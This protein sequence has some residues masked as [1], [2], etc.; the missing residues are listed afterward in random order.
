M[1]PLLLTAS[2]QG[3]KRQRGTHCVCTHAAQATACQLTVGRHVLGVQLPLKGQPQASRV[4]AI[5]ADACWKGGQE[6]GQ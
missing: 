1:A 4:D 3:E 2:C 5:V 6:A